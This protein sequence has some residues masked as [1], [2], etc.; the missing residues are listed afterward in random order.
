MNIISRLEVSIGRI[1][2]K[3]GLG[4]RAKLII[5]FVIIKVIPL[6]VLTIMA[7]NQARNLGGELNR[8]TQEL[9]VKSNE[10]LA[11]TGAVAVDDS[12]R[13]LNNFATDDIERISTDMAKRVADFL[14]DRD[15]DIRYAA[16]LRPG[17]ESYRHFIENKRGDL[18]KSG[19]WELSADGSRWVPAK[20]AA[21]PKAVASS[22]RENDTSFRYR[23][24]DNFETESRPLYLEMTYIDLEGNEL[25]KVTSSPRMDSGLKNVADRRNT[26]VKAETYFAEL[27]KLKPGEIYVSDVIGAYVRS[28][29]IGMYTP[30][31]AAAR[32]LE[33]RPEDEAYAGEENPRGKRFQGLIRWA[34]PVT[35][36]GRI[37][38]YVTLALDH[39]HLMEFTDHTTPMR[40]RYTELPSAYEGNYAFIWDYKCRSICHPRHHSIVGFNPETGEP[41]IPWLEEG[42]YEAWQAS[43]KNY[44]EF[45]KGQPAFVEQSRDKK[46]A[47]ALTEAG[48]VGLDGRWL[49]HAP[50]CTGWFDLTSEGGSGSFLI[51]WS[52]IW[53]LTT[54][55]A[56]PY[57]TGHYGQSKRG[58]GFVAIGA[59]FEDFQ[60]P[61]RETEAV[62]D[63][64][65]A[66]AN[67]DLSRAADAH[68]FDD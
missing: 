4:M 60:R 63:K 1:L 10:A 67:T 36:N 66:A 12:V 58:F 18:V 6:V 34:M 59:G 9:T 15:R 43:G 16:G 2:T 33:F 11:K 32:G 44:T 35:E 38:G 62:L 50:Q 53:K 37:A 48:L 41:E 45:I 64:L 23:P 8:R 57:Y 65:I 14:Y 51:L 7:W 27:K 39:D 20:P 3:L 19:E 31:N 5:I 22:N 55:A 42:V 52:G 25:I 17:R 47:A 46:P 30:E 28:R 56:I 29:L 24:P 49:N 68:Y 61:A 40:E 26:Y 13:A 54:A 21:E